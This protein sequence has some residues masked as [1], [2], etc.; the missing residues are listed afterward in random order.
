[1]GFELQV[2]AY[3]NQ[4]TIITVASETLY[5]IL[6]SIIITYNLIEKAKEKQ[7]GNLL[8]HK[9]ESVPMNVQPIVQFHKGHLTSLL[10]FFA[11]F[12]DCK[13]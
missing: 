6:L 10:F 11:Q 7:N 2:R 9:Q 4:S 3:R 13:T 8:Q 12:T 1:M 5:P